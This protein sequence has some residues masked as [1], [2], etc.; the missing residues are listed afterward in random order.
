MRRKTLYKGGTLLRIFQERTD[1]VFVSE[2]MSSAVIK[3]RY[4]LPATGDFSKMETKRSGAK[5]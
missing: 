5:T 1:I 2:V 4:R 3:L